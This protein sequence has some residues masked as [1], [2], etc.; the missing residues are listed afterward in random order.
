ME[1]WQIE[2]ISL[3]M[4]PRKKSREPKLLP[5]RFL[6]Q[7][8]YSLY[9]DGNMQVN[10]KVDDIL[11]NELTESPFAMFPFTATKSAHRIDGNP[12]T[13]QNPT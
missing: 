5:H 10:N 13:I 3:D 2:N 11:L 8:E 7:Y 12:T 6:D 4:G 9:V 1:G